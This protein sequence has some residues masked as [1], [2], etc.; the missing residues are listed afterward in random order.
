MC[1]C[2]RERMHEGWGG[3]RRVGAIYVMQLDQHV[4]Y[5]VDE[6]HS[7]NIYNFLATVI[8]MAVLYSC[9]FAASGMV[10]EACAPQDWMRYN[11]VNCI[12]RNQQQLMWNGCV[13]KVSTF[14]VKLC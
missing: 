12:Q 5:N 13:N 2:V 8:N 3:G 10:F 14:T 1:V 4:S 11:Y 7:F 6:R 9:C